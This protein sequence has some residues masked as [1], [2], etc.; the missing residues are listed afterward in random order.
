[1]S[2]IINNSRGEIVAVV[3]DGTINTSATDL[4]LVGRAVTE[5]GTYENENYVYLLENF[6]NGSAPLRPIL[7]Q[8]WYNSS[9]D[10]IS[11]YGSGNTWNALAS[12]AYVQAQK[13]SP[14][15]TGV[16][17]TPTAPLGT[18]N[19]QVAST[20]FV[21]A[22]ITTSQNTAATIYA[23][24][25]SPVLTGV[26][27]GPT[28]TAGANTNQLATTAFVTNSAALAGTPTAPTAAANTNSAQIATT[29]FVQNNKISPEFSGV[30]LAPTATA[31]TGTSQIA[32][33]LFV[34]NNKVS[35]AFIG[36]P[37]VPTAPP[38][39]GN[40][41]IASTGFVQQ[42]L[43]SGA[44]GV[45]KTMAYQNAN[46]V[47]ITG[48][49]IINVTPIPVASGGTASN[50]AAGARINLGL[51]TMALQEKESVEILG[52]TITGI[53]DL[54]VADGGTG[55]S[56]AAG[57]RT[58]LGIGTVATQNASNVAITGGSITGITP[59][60][61]NAGGTGAGDP[62]QARLNLGI[63]NLATQEPNSVA[64]TGGTITGTSISS[65]FAPLSIQD[66]GTNSRNA[67][68]A[69]FQLG[70]GSIATQFADSVNITG[71]TLSNIGVNII[72]GTITGV[73]PIAIQSGGTG[74]DTA[75]GART[76]LGLRSG[77]TTDVG[78]IATQNANNVSIT[79]GNV[80]GNNVSGNYV[81][82]FNPIQ[83]QSGGT[84]AN[85]AAG[86]RSS[87]EVPP[88]TRSIIAGGGLAGGGTLQADRT[89]SIASDSNG[90]GR[91]WVSTSTPSSATGSNGDIWYQI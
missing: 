70:L 24:I 6:A 90:F 15:F 52:G 88:D 19:T 91:R 89:L 38:G 3:A 45:L 44:G 2:Y 81:I 68:D 56:T 30:P 59:I 37:T 49:S 28:A 32:T 66:G 7:G 25:N 20:G 36:V 35:P 46:N 34:Q 83:V 60:A 23:P 55:A 29:A 43:A 41:Q 86:A 87:L 72:G 58:N 26:P 11:A 27:Q 75:S 48:G 47:A 1:M 9:T 61:V 80:S 76:N 71:G 69:R 54:A 74:S 42:E 8:L 21:S 22:A 5:Y 14:A 18:A 31:N 65:L 40:A 57:A 33:T 79:G 16:P 62:I 13:I 85:T 67:F 84:G 64:I 4:T 10:T 39:T 53:T 12:Q 17:T 73:S 63:G 82:S 77:A 50:T 78:T 51:G